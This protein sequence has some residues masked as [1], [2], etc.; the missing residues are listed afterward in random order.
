[1]ILFVLAFY[2]S[3]CLLAKK[4]INERKANGAEERKREN[5]DCMIMSF[6]K[7][8]FIGA[9]LIYSVVLV[10]GIRQSES[11]IHICILF[12]FF[13]SFP[14]QAITEYEWSSQC[15]IHQ[16]LIH[17]LF[18]IQQCGSDGKESACDVG[19]LRSVP[20]LGRA[21]GKGN[22]Y[23]LRYSGLAKS[24]DRGGWQATVP[25]PAKSRTRLNDHTLTCQ[26]VSVP[27]PLPL[28]S[29]WTLGKLNSVNLPVKAYLRTGSSLYQFR[30]A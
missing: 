27:V 10:S 14:I 6:L 19:D 5:V 22:S 4:H 9:Q 30:L 23:P 8:F 12:F 17:Y 16:V 28:P 2:Q 18:Y 21:P 15:Y 13:N 3:L 11:V 25:G 24:T 26:C 20:G 29:P 1:M 7:N